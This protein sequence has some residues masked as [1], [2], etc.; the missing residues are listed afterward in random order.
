MDAMQVQAMAQE[1]ERRRQARIVALR[2][3]LRRMDDGEFG[4]CAECGEPIPEKRLEIDPTALV[5][6]ACASGGGR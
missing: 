6:V 2:A 3:A 1:S 4:E 5:C